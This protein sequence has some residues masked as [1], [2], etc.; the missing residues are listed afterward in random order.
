[1]VSPKGARYAMQVMPA[2]ARDPGY[3]V[4]PALNDTPAEYNR[5]GNDYLGAL[6]QRYGD[7]A[8]MWAA[9]N[10]GPSRV[11][12]AIRRH[13]PDWLRG[14][15]RETQEYVARNLQALGE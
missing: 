13:G 3:G 12:K 10:A 8:K 9:Y 1:M 15:P 7:P 5:V 11:D 4:R 14:L 6:R 2:T